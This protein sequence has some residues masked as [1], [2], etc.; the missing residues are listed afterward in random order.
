[1]TTK[2]ALDSNFSG[3][4]SKPWYQRPR[5]NDVPEGF[6]DL[7]ALTKAVLNTASRH[8]PCVLA[9]SLSAE[10]MVLFHLIVR[11]RLPIHTFALDTNRLPQA[12]LT[13]WLHAEAHYGRDIERINPAPDHLQTLTATQTNSAIFESKTAREL[14]CTVRKTEPLRRMLADK[15]AWVTGLRKAQSAGRTQL[16]HQQWDASFGLEKFNPLVDWSDAALWYFIEHERIPFSALYDKGYASIGCDP[17]TRAIRAGEH[18]RAGRWWWEAAAAA[19][20]SATECGIHV[21]ARNASTQQHNK[22]TV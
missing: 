15:T 6:A 16:A 8:A 3:N 4:Q 11:E 21:V 22:A 17:C 5:V 14:C 7:L 19:S 20:G 18:S 9:S 12:T 2:S 13:L 10:D 1:M